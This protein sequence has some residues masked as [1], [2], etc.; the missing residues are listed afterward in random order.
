V[1]RATET[2]AFHSSGEGRWV[3]LIGIA[4]EFF[5]DNGRNTSSR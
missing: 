5:H 4:S 2:V 1:N 3:V